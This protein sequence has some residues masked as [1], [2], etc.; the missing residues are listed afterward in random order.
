MSKFKPISSNLP[1]EGRLDQTTEGPRRVLYAKEDLPKW[2]HSQAY[3]E[4]YH[5][6]EDLG[7]VCKSKPNSSIVESSPAVKKILEIFTKMTKLVETFPPHGDN[8]RYGNIAFREWFGEVIKLTPDWMTEILHTK[9][10]TIEKWE[11]SELSA[12]FK[13]SFGNNTRID[14]GTGHETAFAA[15]MYCLLKVG[16]VTK[17]DKLA[18]V[19][20]VFSAYLEMIRFVQKTYKLEPAGSHGV[21]GLDDYQFLSFLWGAHQLI[22]HKNITPKSI[23]NKEVVGAYSNDYL[24]LSGIQFINS[25]KRGPFHE[26]SPMLNDISGVLTWEKVSGGMLKM[27]RAEVLDK[28]VV[29]QHFLFGKCLPFDPIESEK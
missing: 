19:I 2:L 27:Y 25:V 13:E 22:G 29:I 6:V 28:F 12:Y 17:E 9:S 26:H 16:V 3:H 5:F 20:Q 11:L 4:L 18:L 21:W 10:E 24:Y 15:W 14:Y 8:S 7:Q 23:H 1:T